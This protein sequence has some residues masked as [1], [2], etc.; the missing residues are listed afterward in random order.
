MGSLIPWGTVR[1]PISLLV[2][3]AVFTSVLMFTVLLKKPVVMKSGYE[4]VTN[5][6][7]F[8]VS[9]F[10]TWMTSGS[11]CMCEILMFFCSPRFTECCPQPLLLVAQRGPARAQGTVSGQHSVKRGL[12]KNA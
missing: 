3:V 5:S 9:N 12:Q 6:A 2:G 1:C 11:S 4:I 10:L 8:G 7:G